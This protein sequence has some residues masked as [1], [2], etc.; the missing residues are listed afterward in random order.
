VRLVRWPNKARKEALVDAV[1]DP[2]ARLIPA[3]GLSVDDSVC[4]G[5][6]IAG[7]GR[8]MYAAATSALN[9]HGDASDGSFRKRPFRSRRC[10]AG[11]TR[12]ILLREKGGPA[13]MPSERLGIPAYAV[14]PYA[15][16]PPWLTF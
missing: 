2:R 5:S 7:N 13:G 11:C 8:L 10:T 9:R 12:R 16:R 3:G 14:T 6:V 4:R 15:T 1:I